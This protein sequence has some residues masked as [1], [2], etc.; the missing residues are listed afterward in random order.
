MFDV[1]RVKKRSDDVRRWI[2]GSLLASFAGATR[3]FD[4]KPVGR[5]KET[6]ANNITY[7]LVLLASLRL[8]RDDTDDDGGGFISYARIIERISSVCL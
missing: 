7:R 3:D 6:K 1:D 2:F 5:E 8:E 4:G